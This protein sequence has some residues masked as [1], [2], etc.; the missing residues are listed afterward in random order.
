M[1]KR[2]KGTKLMA[3]ADR[4]GLPLAVHTAAAT[5]HEVTLVPDTLVQVFTTELPERLIGDKAYDS[6]PLDASLATVGIEMIAPHRTNRQQPAT[7]DGRPLRRY[8]RRW[9]ME[10]LFAWLQNFRRLVVRHEYH[11]EN[12]LGFVHWACILIL[13]RCY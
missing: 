11:A 6:D 5:P 1:T 10:R 4:T 8:R 9:K 13:L 3:V 7:Q 12:F 2:G